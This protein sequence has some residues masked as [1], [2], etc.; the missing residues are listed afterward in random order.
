[1]VIDGHCDV[2]YKL[3]SNK[4]LQ[5][6]AHGQD[7]IL[8]AGLPR[9]IEGGVKLQFCAI[10][11][12]EDEV[13]TP[14]F[15]HVLE[16]VDIYDKQLL[17]Q[18]M[19][20]PVLSKADLS[21][22][23][24]DGKLGTLLHIEGADALEG[25]LMLLRMV[26]RL[27]VR[28]MGLTWNYSNWA[29]DGAVEPRQGGLTTKGRKFIRECERIGI[30]LDVSHLSERAFWDLEKE[31]KKPFF[32]SHSNV[33]DICPHNRNLRRDQLQAI[34]DRDGLVGLTFVPYFVKQDK[35]ATIDDFLRHVDYV[36]ALGGA[37]KLAFGSDFDGFSQM[38]PGLEH[39]GHFVNLANELY[40]R[41]KPE[42]VEGFLFGNW[43]RFLSHN[44][45]D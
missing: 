17:S 30:I 13:G 9:L 38:I 36:C 4:Q 3:F 28:T 24:E 34:L 33:Y 15:R 19:I 11:I 23:N 18:P 45:P 27:G 29:A 20:H 31:T 43:H 6:D 25:D 41:Y 7:I 12:D 37:D 8:Q 10:F 44:L 22:M 32:A 2:L 35:D 26:Y 39:A 5:F 1:M 14:T 40:K 16:Y 42:E 21:V